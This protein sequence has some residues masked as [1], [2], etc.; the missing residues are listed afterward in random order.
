MSYKYHNYLITFHIYLDP[1][2]TP[3]AKGK[4]VVVAK[5]TSSGYL[6]TE[7]IVGRI[8]LSKEA[9]WPV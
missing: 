4:A 3:R 5:V 8:K 2:H 7:E 9:K 1:K 6:A